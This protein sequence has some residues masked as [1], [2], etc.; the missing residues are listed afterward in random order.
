MPSRVFLCASMVPAAT[1]AA[2][3]GPDFGV[4]LVEMSVAGL[5]EIPKTGIQQTTLAMG[6]AYSLAVIAFLQVSYFFLTRTLTT[7]LQLVTVSGQDTPTAI[8]APSA[9][10][11]GA[12]VLFAS[13][14]HNLLLLPESGRVK[15]V[16]GGLGTV[17]TEQTKCHP[18]DLLAVH[19]VAL[20]H[21]RGPN[22]EPIPGANGEP[23]SIDSYDLRNKDIW[24]KQAPL[25]VT[26]DGQEET[27]ELYES[28]PRRDQQNPQA[29]QVTYLMMDHEWFRNRG[30]LYPSRAESLNSLKF[31]SLFNQ[32][33]GLLIVKYSPWVFQCPDYLPALAP[34]YAWKAGQPPRMAL[35]LHNAEYQG[36]V[37][38]VQV[39][40][41]EL[42]RLSAVFN[43]PRKIIE[44]HMV[45]DGSFN[46]LY[47]GA[48]YVAMAQRGR[49]LASVSPRYAEEAQ[50]RHQMFWGLGEIR[51]INNPKDRDHRNEEL[52]NQHQPL[53]ATKRDAKRAAQ[54]RFG[55]RINDDARLLVFL[56]RWVK[57]KGV[58][59]IADCAEWM[60]ASYPNL[61]LL[62]LG[63][64]T[65]DDSF[66]VYAHQCLKRL[67]SQAKAG[68]RF[69]G[70]LH[71]SGEFHDVRR[72]AR[73]RGF[74]LYHAADFCLMVSREEPFGYVDV[75]FAWG[76]ALTIGT[77]CGG[78]GKVPGIYFMPRNVES[79]QA[80]R[81]CFKAA[82]KSAMDM[83]PR[84]FQALSAEAT[85][86]TFSEDDWRRELLRL[87][88][89]TQIALHR[90]LRTDL[91]RVVETENAGSPVFEADIPV[92][93]IV[94]SIL[95]RVTV[96][97][98]QEFVKPSS[99]PDT[100]AD[101]VWEHS[102]RG[103]SSWFS[104]L[105]NQRFLHTQIID[106]VLVLNYILTPLLSLWCAMPDHSKCSQPASWIVDA[107]ATREKCR[108]E[109]VWQIG[110]QGLYIISSFFWVFLS[111]KVQ[112]C[113][114]LAVVTLIRFVMLLAPFLSYWGVIG[115]S[116]YTAMITLALGFI[117]GSDALFIFYGFMSAAVGDVCKLALRMGVSLGILY[118]LTQFS[119]FALSTAGQLRGGL[120]VLG[121]LGAAF[122]LFLG[123]CLFYAPKPYQNFTLPGFSFS[124]KRRSLIFLALGWAISGATN[125]AMDRADAAI[126]QSLT[127]DRK[128][129]S[130]V[131]R[132][133][134]YFMTWVA[135][136]FSLI[137]YRF[138]SASPRLVKTCTFFLIPPGFIRAAVLWGVQ[139][140]DLDTPLLDTPLSRSL[141]VCLVVSL[142]I[143]MVQSIS[144]FI[145]I[146]ST[147]QS[148]WRFIVFMTICTPGAATLRALYM[149]LDVTDRLPSVQLCLI[150]CSAAQWLATVFASVFFDAESSALVTRSKKELVRRNTE[151]YSGRI[152]QL[153]ELH[154]AQMV[155]RSDGQ[156]RPRAARVDTSAHD[157][158]RGMCCIWVILF[159]L[160]AG[161]IQFF[162]N[163][164]IS[165]D[166]QGCAIMPIF[167][168][169][170]GFVLVMVYGQ[171]RYLLS[172]H[173]NEPG[174]V[175]FPYKE[176]FSKRVARL[177]P[178]YYLTT[179]LAVPL[180]WL[181]F[182]PFAWAD[183][184][185]LVG[186]VVSN[187]LCLTTLFNC[188]LPPW[189]YGCQWEQ[190]FNQTVNGTNGT[191]TQLPPLCNKEE[192]GL[193]IGLKN[194]N[195]PSWTVCTLVWFYLAF[196]FL[197]KYIQRFNNMQLF[198]LIRI[199]YWVQLLVSIAL[200]LVYT[201]IE[202]GGFG[203]LRYWNIAPGEL[204][205]TVATQ[206]PIFRVPVFIMGICAGLLCNRHAADPGLVW[207]GRFFYF[208]PGKEL[209]DTERHKTLPEDE[210]RY[211]RYG[212]LWWAR[213]VDRTCLLLAVAFVLE[214]IADCIVSSIIERDWSASKRVPD[215]NHPGKWI[216]KLPGPDHHVQGLGGALWF[217]A[218]LPYAFLTVV[219]GLTRSG[220]D[221]RA[222][223]FFSSKKMKRLGA[224]SFS[225]YLVHFPLL[226][227]FNYLILGHQ[228]AGAPLH[229]WGADEP[230]PWWGAI[231]VFLGALLLGS[232]TYYYFEEPL[233]R[234]LNG[235]RQNRP[236][237]GAAGA[238]GGDGVPSFQLAQARREP[239]VSSPSR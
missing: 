96:Q 39:R 90:D 173:H 166:L 63:P 60:L 188:Q 195:G 78:L 122:K 129:L 215:P 201:A 21:L 133:A 2:V 59:L 144:M 150:A 73:D 25:V 135:M 134:P 216:W 62:I 211:G 83:P 97:P 226:E 102:L 172:G 65:N 118:G 104:H 56:G 234:C 163:Y 220:T 231:L 74:S 124:W 81:D 105:L 194:I 176:F 217:Q 224:F 32:G 203:Q 151:S 156:A 228:P 167:F 107:D 44:E 199:C 185:T 190:T 230:I 9:A 116:Q 77:L 27:I 40:R 207:S 10:P 38:H 103:E 187:I 145:V 57:Q 69:D 79:L 221:S 181:G 47:A 51:G 113:K 29:P 34:W 24:I 91:N 98:N 149:Y 160:M 66:G 93:E 72:D 16:A 225:V 117:K 198:I 68:Q 229:N 161:R 126:V 155:E 218:I 170:S 92:E 138:P 186:S 11:Q 55:L 99:C 236:A 61:Q 67:A 53:W 193:P 41:P 50:L 100:L 28:H 162:H 82:V 4:E 48:R 171:K 46:M 168:L 115:G 178:A 85:L 159:H 42:Q 86:S 141:V 214:I 183:T 165:I 222:Y 119:R 191:G 17:V 23:T 123:C 120:V 8:E 20:S 136:F 232:L 76:G 80:V 235:E 31:F 37:C 137:L 212:R 5:T 154:Q 179:F 114:I 88:H 45:Y 174:A 49:G 131:V 175:D 52:Y 227:Y 169:L 208:F 189:P 112:P 12:K 238:A 233:R 19:A 206:N 71:V 15:C 43:L 196:P 70:R 158:I 108:R 209:P 89:G 111:T 30:T 140:Q 142:V 58:D 177:L 22:G 157:G 200:F 139:V 94:Q 164:Q 146:L 202:Y 3:T 110:G 239:A 35:V 125:T 182:G 33:V 36:A 121:L 75:E 26:V 109:H 132:G 130:W 64:E 13:L 205:F 184:R 95:T 219:V 87:Y 128:E 204:A 147:V 148:R 153:R 213:I 152:A 1:W 101:V 6:L 143:Q 54:E 14:E 18:T 237:A 210:Q 192:R 180:I 197:L 223:R 106:W 84:D 7:R 127:L